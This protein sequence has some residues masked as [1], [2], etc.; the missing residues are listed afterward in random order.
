MEAPST[1]V[2]Y[3]PFKASVITNST[4]FVVLKKKTHFEETNVTEVD[5]QQRVCAHVRILRMS[6]SV[7]ARS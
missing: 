7:L 1:D 6:P 3:N 2:V 5:T 4:E